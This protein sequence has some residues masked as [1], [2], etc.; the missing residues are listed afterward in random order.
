MAQLRWLKSVHQTEKD[1]A[2]LVTHDD[3]LLERLTQSGA[4]GGQLAIPP[5]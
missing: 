5:H 1:L 2:I 3:D 4:I